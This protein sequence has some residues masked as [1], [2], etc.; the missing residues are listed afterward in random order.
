MDVLTEVIRAA[1]IR[2]VLYGRLEL[3]APW[4]MRV[5]GPRQLVFYAV[6]RGGGVLDVRGRSFTV[7]VGDLVF[8]RE[9]VP[10]TMKDHPRSRAATVAEVYAQRGGRCGG[11]VRYGGEGAATTILSGGFTF[12]TKELNPVLELLPDV[13]HVVAEDDGLVR[14]LDSTLRLMACEMQ[15]EEPGYEL[16]ATRL[17]DVLFVH[18]LRHRVK[19]DTCEAGWLRAVGDPQLGP[20][21]Q[22]LHAR[23]EAPWTVETLAREAAMSRSAFAQRFK[24]VV[25]QAPLAYLT[26]WR[27]YRAVELLGGST[28]SV[29]E[30]A[31]AVGYETESAFAKVF[32]RHLG[33]TPAAHRRRA[34]A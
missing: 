34:R 31:H 18:A 7:G 26:R 10:H 1:R 16:I 8:V 25:G 3:T 9:G 23:P 21:L 4:G 27:M 13:F 28:R 32:K 22:R 19:K 29:A 5:E 24:Q 14:W 30:V 11:L 6:A 2:S 17:A 33:T 12:E 20:M 15:V